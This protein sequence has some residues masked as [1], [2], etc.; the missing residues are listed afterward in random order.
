MIIT[1]D[2][3]NFSL[4]EILSFFKQF[5]WYETEIDRYYPNINIADKYNL[6]N[7][8]INLN[9]INFDFNSDEDIIQNNKFLNETI[10][11]NIEKYRI[12]SSYKDT[13]VIA[14]FDV[15]KNIIT[16]LYNGFYIHYF[17]GDLDSNDEYRY[18]QCHSGVGYNNIY[19]SKILKNKKQDGIIYK[20]NNFYNIKQLENLFDNLIFL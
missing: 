6:T 16:S 19:I 3:I 9:N 10:T 13:Y 20:D 1:E 8:N 17:T 2:M 11:I 4:K 7:D 5:P 12:C 15:N 14:L 18:F